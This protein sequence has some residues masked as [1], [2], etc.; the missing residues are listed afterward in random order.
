LRPAVLEFAYLFFLNNK[1][2]ERTVLTQAFDKATI[3]K[4][5]DQIMPLYI[6]WLEIHID[7]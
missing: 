7:Q 6:D 5:V 2:K 3:E 4:E 1:M